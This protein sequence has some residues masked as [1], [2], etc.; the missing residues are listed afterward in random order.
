MSLPLY[1]YAANLGPEL[2]QSSSATGPMLS[3]K[4]KTLLVLLQMDTLSGTTL[5]DP[6][7]LSDAGLEDLAGDESDSGHRYVRVIIYAA[8]N[9]LAKDRNGYSDPY[10]EGRL[11][12]EKIRSRVVQQTTNPNWNQEF[13]MKMAQSENPQDHVLK[14]TA[15]DYD[16]PHRSPDFLGQLR[17]PLS[18]VLNNKPE[19]K[20][21]DKTCVHVG[22]E[23]VHMHGSQK[24]EQSAGSSANDTALPA[25][26][27]N[28]DQKATQ[29]IKCMRM[30]LLVELAHMGGLG[31]T[32]MANACQRLSKR[33]F[34]ASWFASY[35][36]GQADAG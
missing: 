2:Q 21:T 19:L 17:L 1:L 7:A 11:A 8:R 33:K 20:A 24:I 25:M 35:S 3:S 4:G 10:V 16:G 32:Q 34:R 36:A 26:K 12:G 27:D 22:S 31:S 14:L 18:D 23:L 13:V 5:D 6:A 29:H 28:V 30:Q 15:W 9:V